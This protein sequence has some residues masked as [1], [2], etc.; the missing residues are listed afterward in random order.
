MS[1]FSNNAIEYTLL[2]LFKIAGVNKLLKNVEVFNTLDGVNVVV[3]VGENKLIEFHLVNDPEINCLLNGESEFSSIASFDK[4]R[5]IPVFGLNKNDNFALIRQN[6]LIINADIIS[7]S[8]ILLSRYEEIF[9]KERDRHQR[10][11]FK[12]SLACKY[13]FIDIPIVDEYAMLLRKWLVMF[14][15]TL[16][17]IKRKGKVIPTHDIDNIQRFGGFLQNFKTIIG[18]DIFIRKSFSVAF[19]SLR[20]CYSSICNRYN[21]PYIVAI[22]RLIDI[23]REAGLCSEF[24]FMGLRNG[25]YD[26]RYDIY[27]SKVKYCMDLVTDANM[28]VGMH[29]GY[30]SFCNN[31]IFQQE[32]N[33][34]EIVTNTDTTSGRQHYLMFDIHTTI[35]VWQNSHF[36]LDSTLGYAEREGFRCGTC[37]EYFLYDHKHDC[38]STVKERPLIVMD[39][40]LFEYRGLSIESALDT[41]YRLNSRCQDVEGDFVMVWHNESMFRDYEDKFLNVYCE[42]IKSQII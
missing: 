13:N 25:Q 2:Q 1:V 27:N 8:F 12:N 30:N 18:G 24:Y 10:F 3:E 26:S 41:L 39:R 7:L 20:S 35:H 5:D 22:K 6:K 14:I 38:V 11:E 32:K 42:F 19:D 36:L 37:H 28:I 34:I 9:L 31:E 21:D 4:K 29:G 33:D 23:S 16:Q 15:P 17:Y 40:T